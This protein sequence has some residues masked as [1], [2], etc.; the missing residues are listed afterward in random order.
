MSNKN[1]NYSSQPIEEFTLFRYLT[2]EQKEL[3]K[4][5]INRVKYRG[6]ETII[7]EGFAASHLL[8]LESGV[9]KLNAEKR[10]KSITFKILSSGNF[11]GLMCAFVNKKVDFSAV[12]ATDSVVVLVERS[13]VETLIVENGNFALDL[14]KSV[15][16][17]TNEV[18]HHLINL[19]DKNLPGIMA[20]LL[21]DLF[22]IFGSEHFTLPFTRSELA[23]TIGYSKE[24]V[25]NIL[26]Q[27]TQDD[28]IELSGKKVYL[29]ELKKLQEI[30]TFG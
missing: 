1:Y 29:K 20:T 11:I 10:G 21:L 23:D 14:L 13:M 12:A 19:T 9:V 26:S 6:G 7:K 2:Q 22:S 3:L 8:Y 24:S 4:G 30:A 27:F 25:S 18:V 5:S 16:E 15:S 17:M 28:L